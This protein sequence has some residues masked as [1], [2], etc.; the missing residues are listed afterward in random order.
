MT[1]AKAKTSQVKKEFDVN[2]YMVTNAVE[3]KKI[4]VDDTT[5]EVKIKPLSWSRKNQLVAQAMKFG[6]DSAGMSFDADS[7]VKE[8]LKA[9]LVDAPW[10][11]TTDTFLISINEKLGRALETLVPKAFEDANEEDDELKKE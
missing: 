2:Q 8:C 11:K 4:A 10:G 9:I 7:Y 3:T 5:F 6:S 1:T